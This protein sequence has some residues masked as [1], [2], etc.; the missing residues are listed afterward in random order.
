MI[1]GNRS[2][3]FA[4]VLAEYEESGSDHCARA[5]ADTVTKNVMTR[6]RI[7]DRMIQQIGEENL[8]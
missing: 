6:N 5:D 4:E 1:G 7:T 3:W 8:S 2:G